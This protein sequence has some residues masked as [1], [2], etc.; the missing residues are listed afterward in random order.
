MV[1]SLTR[2][3]VSSVHSP[4]GVGP[5]A[6]RSGAF[7]NVPSPFVIVIVT[8]RLTSASPFALRTTKAGDGVTMVP[9]TTSGSPESDASIANGAVA[10]VGSSPQAAK[11]AT[12]ASGKNAALADLTNRRP[13][14]TKHSPGIEPHRQRLRAA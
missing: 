8:G 13:A 4:T 14:T 10:L 12:V 7:V 5:A 6:V 11:P 2:A 1:I 3:M 9:T